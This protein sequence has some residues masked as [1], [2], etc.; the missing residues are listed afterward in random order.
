MRLSRIDD[1]TRREHYYLG[2]QD[3]CFYLGE[4]SARKGG[5]F[6]MTSVLETLRGRGGPWAKELAAGRA[7]RV[8]VNQQMGEAAVVLGDGDEVAFFPPVTGG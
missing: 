6:G 3:T 8:A 4:Y 7:V 2:D 1:L 5:A